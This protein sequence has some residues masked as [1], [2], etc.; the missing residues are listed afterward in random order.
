MNNVRKLFLLSTIFLPTLALVAQ[1]HP[2]FTGTWKLDVAKSEMG[3]GGPTK[4][5]VVVDH[6]DPVFKYLVQGIAAGGQ[7]E[8]SETFTTDGKTSRDS[9]GVNVKASWDGAELVAVGTAD[10][11]SMVYLSRLTL[12]PDGKTITR[13]FTQKNDRELRHEIYEK[14]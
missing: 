2:N 10:D 4:L 12:S 7:F 5:V 9:H 11:G 6:K 13:V 3:S 14:Q 8:E 1:G